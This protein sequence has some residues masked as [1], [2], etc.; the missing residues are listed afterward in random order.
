MPV[1]SPPPPVTPAAPRAPVTPT[2]EQLTA[3]LPHGRFIAD[4]LIGVGGMGAVYRGRQLSLERPIAIKMLQR[5]IGGEWGFEDRF[6]RE[7][8]AMARLNHPNIVSV[9]DYGQIDEDFLYLVME[10]VEGTDLAEVLR[11]GGVTL[12]LTMMI[13]PQICLALE[14]AHAK[15]IVHR[16]IK[17]ANIL[18][19]RQGEAKLTDFGLAKRLDNMNSFITK[20]HLIMGTAEYAAPEQCSAHREVDHRADIYALGVVTYQMLTGTLPKGAWQSP[21]S[22]AGTDPRLDSLV[23]RAM[24]PDRNQRFQSVAEFRRALHEIATTSPTQPRP[25]PTGALIAPPSIAP[26]QTRRVLLLEDDLLVRDILRRYLELS[27]FQV[28]ETGDGKDTVTAYTDALRQGWRYDLVIID[29]TI[30][31]GV[32]GAEAMR[33][34]RHYD[35]H[36]TAIVSSGY[37][38]DPIMRNPGAHGFAAALPKPYHRES[39]LQVVNGVL[40]VGKG[41]G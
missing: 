14:H 5:G 1:I 39:L 4:K 16:D 13:L 15:G 33:S 32:S 19:T 26:G 30:P 2:P 18:L 28:T 3:V 12:P 40:A 27:G 11:T 8:I 6:Q 31:D 36:V 23:V 41:R 17:P 10:Y 35:P 21:S 38:D 24:M 22:K 25:S 7:A 34:L 20:T 9:F 29:L 37:R